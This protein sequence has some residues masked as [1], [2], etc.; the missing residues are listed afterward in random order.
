MIIKAPR[1]G[2][3]SDFGLIRRSPAMRRPSP[4][5]VVRCNEVLQYIWDPI[6]VAG[7]PGA[8]DEY[9][10]YVPSVAWMA[11]DGASAERITAYLMGVVETRMGLEPRQED[12]MRAAQV[13]LDWSEWL[14]ASL[15]EGQ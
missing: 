15:G 11:C 14:R 2:Y 3:L 10:G 9:D 1:A 6:G 8:R 12:A 13:I 4:E 7:E 5:L